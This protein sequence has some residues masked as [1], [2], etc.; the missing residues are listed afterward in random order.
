M[1]L[2]KRPRA[3]RYVISRGRDQV[4]SVHVDRGDGTLRP[5]R[6]VK[7]HSPSGM[8]VGYSG[9]GPSDLALSLLA[10]LL[11][12]PRSAR[13]YQRPRGNAAQVW[14]L[15]HLVRQ[16]FLARLELG[17]G[18]SAEIDG[19]ELHRFALAE[20]ERTRTA[21]EAALALAEAEAAAS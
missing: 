8:E 18:A 12:G 16:R 19:G 11:G 17:R 1:R 14:F 3:A 5:V 21:R 9:S 13:A 10:D 7:V 6:H 15:H 2:T 20:L 4:V